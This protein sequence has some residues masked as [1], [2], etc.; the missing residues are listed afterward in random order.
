MGTANQ[1][2]KK[3]EGKKSAQMHHLGL[4]S[5]PDHL[6]LLW[7]YCPGNQQLLIAWQTERDHKMA[8]LIQAWTPLPPPLP[9]SPTACSSGSVDRH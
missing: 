2:L 6:S 4:R 9:P 5:K 8:P 1:T 7:D 3:K